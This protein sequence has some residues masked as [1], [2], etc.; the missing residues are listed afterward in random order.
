MSKHETLLEMQDESL[1]TIHMNMATFLSFMKRSN[2]EN[3]LQADRSY[4]I[5]LGFVTINGTQKVI[6]GYKQRHI[7]DTD[8]TRLCEW[9]E[10]IR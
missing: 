8:Y 1:T 9:I 7:R 3:P 2:N 10:D 5:T 4:S 6:L